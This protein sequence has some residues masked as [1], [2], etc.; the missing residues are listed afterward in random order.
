LLVHTHAT[1]VP[2]TC[3]AVQKLHRHGVEHLVAHQHTAQNLRQTVRPLHPI[4]PRGQT[5]TLAFAQS[6]RQVNDGVAAR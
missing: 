1:F 6:P 4:T 5:L 2:H 3:D